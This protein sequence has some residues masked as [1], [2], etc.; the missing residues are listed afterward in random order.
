MHGIEAKTPQSSKT[1]HLEDLA[2]MLEQALPVPGLEK[3]P[4]DFWKGQPILRTIDF[5]RGWSILSTQAVANLACF[6]VLEPT[7]C[8]MSFMIGPMYSVCKF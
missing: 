8:A 3:A 6:Q 1:H 4:I 7:I 5:H 2:S